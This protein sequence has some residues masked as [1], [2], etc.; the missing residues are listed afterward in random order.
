MYYMY[1]RGGDHKANLLAQDSAARLTLV[2]VLH[3]DALELEARSL[4]GFRG[5]KG[6]GH[7]HDGAVEEDD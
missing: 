1:D 3:G 5:E 6:G 4:T 2:V 7:D